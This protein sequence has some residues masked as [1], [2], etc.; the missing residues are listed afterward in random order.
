[1]KIT[2]LTLA[3]GLHIPLVRMNAWYTYIMDTFTKYGIDGD[4]ER[5]AFLAQACYE[6]MAFKR[7]VE[8]LNYTSEVR[9]LAVFKDHVKPR[10]VKQFLRNPEK[11][12]NRVYANRLGNGDEASGDGWSFLGR[13]L[14][15][16]TGR[17]HYTAYSEH[18]G[19]DC[20]ADPFRVAQWDHACFS[21]GWYWR[22]NS[23]HKLV[24]DFSL[25][26]KAIS[27]SQYTTKRRFAILESLQKETADE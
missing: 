19:Y 8:N 3:R 4:Q 5:L 13:G 21:A 12:A 27:G 11:L 6:S 24:G 17:D 18:I 15:M 14:F 25:L 26:T 2:S 23:L 16:L 7:T 10:E 22:R 1:M 9:L 20:V